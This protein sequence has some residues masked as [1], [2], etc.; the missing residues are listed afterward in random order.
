MCNLCLGYGMERLRGIISNCG[1]RMEIVLLAAFRK[2]S[3]ALIVAT[4]VSFA[5]I[6]NT[7]MLQLWAC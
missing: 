7:V 4:M 2:R 5:L 1:R 6:F 3:L